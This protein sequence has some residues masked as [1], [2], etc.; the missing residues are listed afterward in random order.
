MP[1]QT[2]RPLHL[3]LIYDL[4]E[5]ATGLGVIVMAI[6]PLAVPGLVLVIVPLMAV[7]VAGGLVS[8]VLALPMIAVYRLARLVRRRLTGRRAPRPS[9]QPRCAGADQR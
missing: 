2:N 7:A 1:L 3:D 4:L 5:F 6:F 9:V 8:L